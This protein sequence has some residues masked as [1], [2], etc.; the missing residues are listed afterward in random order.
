M[1]NK[2]QTP[3]HIGFAQYDGAYCRLHMVAVMLQT[4]ALSSET[5][6]LDNKSCKTHILPPYGLDSYGPLWLGPLWRVQAIG[7]HAV[8]I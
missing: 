1:I 8:V 3:K 7:G 6:M 4:I 5:M 2:K